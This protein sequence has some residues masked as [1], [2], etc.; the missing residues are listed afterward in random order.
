MQQAAKAYRAGEYDTM[1]EALKGVA[2]KRRR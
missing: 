1:S 2:A